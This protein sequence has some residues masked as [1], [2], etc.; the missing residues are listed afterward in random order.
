MIQCCQAHESETCIERWIVEGFHWLDFYPRDVVVGG[1]L[2]R[3]DYYL[4]A[5]TNFNHLTCWLFSGQSR[6]AEEFEPM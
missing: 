4:N 6:K 1:E 3:S 5:V 2:E